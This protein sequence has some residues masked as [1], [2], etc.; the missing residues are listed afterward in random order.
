[1]SRMRAAMVDFPA[2]APR[3]QHSSWRN[4][5]CQGDATSYEV[6]QFAQQF[7]SIARSVPCP[8]P[9]ERLRLDVVG[10]GSE[11]TRHHA[12]PG[13]WAA[14]RTRTRPPHGHITCVAE[15]PDCE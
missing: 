14:I 3:V 6:G 13:V 4:A 5:G 1:M 12:S 11:V 7:D 10:N 9:G 8:P 2:I 15:R